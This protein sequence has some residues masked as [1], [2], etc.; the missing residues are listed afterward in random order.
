MITVNGENHGIRGGETVLELLEAQG[1]RLEIIAVE[2]NG[3]ILKK[4]EY[5][6]TVLQDGDKLEVV[7]FVG[8]G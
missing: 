3:V 4:D 6:T 8:G 7:S 2:Y 5:G 1:Y